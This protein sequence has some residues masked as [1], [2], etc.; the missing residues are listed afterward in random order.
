[1][2]KHNRSRKIIVAV[3]GLLWA[4]CLIGG[5]PHGEA[6]Q[7]IKIVTAHSSQKAFGDLAELLAW[8]AIKPKGYDVEFKAMAT[9][10]LA[11]QALVNRD[12]QFAAISS[13]TGMMAVQAG[14]KIKMV[15]EHKANEW[16][17]VTVSSITDP[18]QLA[19]KRL[20]VHSLGAIS[21]GMVRNTLKLAGV[22]LNLMTIAGSDVR[23]QA[24]LA[25]Q[26]DATP[27]EVY[28]VLNVQ[29]K[30]PG[31]FRILVNYS[32]EM[33]NLNG[34][35]FWVSDE[36][37]AKNPNWVQDLIQANLE[38]R[39]KG[40]ADPKWLVTE[41]K[42]LFPQIEPA[43]VEAG[44]SAYLQADIWNVNGHITPE[45]AAY[46]LKFYSD[47]GTI[48]A[49]DLNPENYY[50]FGPVNAVLKKIGMK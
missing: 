28:D 14:A 33:P 44:V 17:L 39:R 31:K 9:P 37:L 7:P 20:A 3:T 46:S 38:V 29:A 43:L 15:C 34:T 48:K 47:V 2:M 30:A 5:V 8:E 19:G 18:K 6:A 26:I 40:K 25:G 41:G 36:F 50:S 12:A 16:A 4:L 32:K 49:T 21:T 22:D 24:M 23:A 1:M 35:C 13:G 27:L 10:E 45:T 42:R 11:A